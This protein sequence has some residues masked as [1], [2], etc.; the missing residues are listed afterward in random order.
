MFYHLSGPWQKTLFFHQVETS[1]VVE[2]SQ[3]ASDV[4]KNFVH[5]T[6]IGFLPA[7]TYHIFVSSIGLSKPPP[8]HRSQVPQHPSSTVRSET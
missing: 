3:S 1:H 2:P 8:P 7:H 6:M 4:Q 5:A